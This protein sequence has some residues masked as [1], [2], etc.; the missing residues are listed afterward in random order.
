MKKAQEG[1]TLGS[2]IWRGLGSEGSVTWSRGCTVQTCVSARYKG[3]QMDTNPSV[4]SGTAR[5][6]EERNRRTFGVGGG[7]AIEKKL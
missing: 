7:Y 3:R 6:V 1:L 4:S 2:S 5:P